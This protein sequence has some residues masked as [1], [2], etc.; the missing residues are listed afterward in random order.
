MLLYSIEFKEKMKN[1]RKTKHIRK[2]KNERSIVMSHYIDLN[3]DL[4]ESFGNYTLGIDSE[5]LNH[6]RRRV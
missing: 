6:V 2:I 4:G 1:I 3:S 5:V